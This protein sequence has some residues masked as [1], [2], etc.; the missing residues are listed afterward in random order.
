MEHYIH[1][2]EWPT[3]ESIHFL[4]TEYSSMD[5]M[6]QFFKIV[7]KLANNNH[8]LVKPSRFIL[9][10]V[11]ETLILNRQFNAPIIKRLIGTTVKKLQE[12]Q[13]LEKYVKHFRRL[14]DSEYLLH[15]K[16]EYIKFIFSKSI[17]GP[18]IANIIASSITLG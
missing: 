12:A 18:Y 14:L 2:P 4:V 11:S 15:C 13:H 3:M 1:I 9:L 8:H 10:V 6:L 17:L 16:K 7:I 5:N